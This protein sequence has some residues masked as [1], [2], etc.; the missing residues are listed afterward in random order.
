MELLLKKW[1]KFFYF[2][3]SK[4]KSDKKGQ[5]FS[6]SENYKIFFRCTVIYVHLYSNISI[7]IKYCNPVQ[8]RTCK[9]P[10]SLYI[11][12][13]IA[14]MFRYRLYYYALKISK[15]VH[16]SNISITQTYYDGNNA[17]TT[18]NMDILFTPWLP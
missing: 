9:L 3:S 13:W 10:D 7:T 8:F 14:T 17:I 1:G 5:E 2:H 6:T 11:D 15:L 16:H 12:F 4:D 18:V